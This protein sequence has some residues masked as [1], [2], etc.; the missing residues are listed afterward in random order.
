[1]AAKKQA[2]KEELIEDA[3]SAGMKA[4]AGRKSEKAAPAPVE[5]RAGLKPA[6]SVKK[7]EAPA[8]KAPAGKKIVASAA[9]SKPAK[10]AAATEKPKAAAKVTAAKES[11]PEAG[12]SV[13]P[14][15]GAAKK[16]A[17]A[18]KPAPAE[19]PQAAKTPS[20]KSTTKAAKKAPAS[21]QAKGGSEAAAAKP[22]PAAP[23]SA[24]ASK[25]TPAGERATAASRKRTAGG[26][27]A[28]KKPAASQAVAKTPVAEP[29]LPAEPV[30]MPTHREAMNFG[31]GEA[32]TAQL[33][34]PRSLPEQPLE[35][36]DWNAFGRTRLVLM[37]RDPEW[38]YVYWEIAPEDRESHQIGHPHGAPPLIL[39]VYDLGESFAPVETGSYFDV[40]VIADASGWYVHAPRSGGH[41]RCDLGY[42]SLTGDFTSLSQ[43]NIVSAPHIGTLEY[44]EEELNWGP[45]A[46]EEIEAAEEVV[47]V[48]EGAEESEELVF[49]GGQGTRVVRRIIVRRKVPMRLLG[50][51]EQARLKPGGASEQV[52][53][54]PGASEQV[55]LRPGASEQRPGASEQLMA[56]PGSLGVKR[57]VGEKAKS[58][59]LQ[60]G[61]ELILYGATEPDA[62]VTVQGQPVKLRP[63]GTFTLRFALPDGEQV[64][65]VRAVNADGDDE[66]VI[67]PIVKKWTE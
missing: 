42:M 7:P 25:T 67:T 12:K 37:V 5:K 29:V 24:P 20:P 61:T 21:V 33:D 14:S 55:G 38:L 41:W 26:A 66:R 60:V 6:E 58:F 39:R 18:G 45:L 64:L 62:T 34:R 16:A 50:A 22:K 28:D 44:G 4:G 54:R 49:G 59:W 27:G 51:S 9:A 35:E 3:E 56:V 11:K 31:V 2:K 17:A 65:P 57:E 48:L 19:P 47:E 43:S 13:K 40:T 10:E 53:L 8:E 30:H 23:K 63:D 32:G 52:G 46:E 1:M 15:A 36:R